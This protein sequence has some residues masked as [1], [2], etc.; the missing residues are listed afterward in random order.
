MQQ[1]GDKLRE[2]SE[3]PFA[4]TVVAL[5][6]YGLAQGGELELE[7]GL[8]ALRVA[9]AKHRLAYALTHAALVDLRLRRPA[10]A[11]ARCLEALAIARVIERPS[12]T[13]LALTLLACAS[14]DLGDLAQAEA[15]RAEIERQDWACACASVRSWHASLLGGDQQRPG[16]T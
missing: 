5:A 6:Q 4:R 1:L 8:Q 15:L 16:D 13:L 3:G 9:D 7:R 14:R 11:R 2:G 10:Q 12:E